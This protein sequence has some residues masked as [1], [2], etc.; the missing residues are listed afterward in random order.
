MNHY[1]SFIQYIQQHNSYSPEEIER[2]CSAFEVEHIASEAELFRNGERYAKVVFVVSGVLRVY[3]VDDSGEEI[4]KNFVAENDFF[5]DMDS[6]DKNL[7]SNLNVSAVTDCT[8]L[9]HSKA[10]SERMK[11]QF[12]NWDYS[13][14][15]AALEATTQMITKQNFLRIGDSSD[16]Y[17][18]FVEKFPYLAQRVPLKY[19]ASYLRITQSSLSRIRKQGWE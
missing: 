13:I 17:R 4:V 8:L 19:V 2:A 12:P 1:D 5:A 10:T 14:K 16:R 15:T 3:I 11:S 18:H 9:T 7:P 6:F